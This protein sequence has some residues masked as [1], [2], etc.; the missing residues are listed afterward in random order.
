MNLASSNLDG[1]TDRRDWWVIGGLVAVLVVLAVWYEPRFA[2]G[3]LVFWPLMLVLMAM[4][5]VLWDAHR[6][7]RTLFGV[8]A[9]ALVGLFGYALAGRWVGSIG[10]GLIAVA[11]EYGAT[12][13]VAALWEQPRTVQQISESYEPNAGRDLRPLGNCR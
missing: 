8:V 9:A 4:A 10:F 7:G 13:A 5:L 11:N 6:R 12:C 2:L 1:A 3:F